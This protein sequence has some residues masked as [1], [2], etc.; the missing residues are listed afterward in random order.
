ML[1]ALS[2]YVTIQSLMDDPSHN[3]LWR[4]LYHPTRRRILDLLR[5]GPRTTG[6]LC[7]AFDSSRYAVMKHLEVLVEARLVTV[8]REG[9]VRWNHLNAVPL[10]EV[11]G[12]WLTPYESLWAS[13]LIRMRDLAESASPESEE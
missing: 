13:N 5:E 6:E 10:Q 4:A 9:R 3:L 1:A 2:I 7:A 11:V 8:R 12:R